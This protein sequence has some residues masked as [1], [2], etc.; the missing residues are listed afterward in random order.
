MRRRFACLA[1]IGWLAVGA[2]AADAATQV[3]ET[4]EP[5]GNCSPRTRIQLSSAGNPYVIPSAGVLTSWS[6]ERASGS[7]IPVR[8]KVA[9]AAGGTSFTIVGE[10]EFENPAVG[11]NT[12]STR[13]AVQAG[14]VLGL[15]AATASVFF[16]T[17]SVLGF[18]VGLGPAFTDE[19]VGMT[20]PY[21][22]V[23]DQQ[24]DVSATLEADCDADGFGDET[25]DGDTNSC[26]PGPQATITK[27][28]RDRVKTRRKRKRATFEFV[29]AEPAT[30]ECALDAAPFT[31]CT[32]PQQVTVKRGTHQFQVRAI[33]AGGNAGVPAIDSWKLKRKRRR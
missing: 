24:L 11:S 8:L 4:F 31:A 25:Q 6:F 27:A 17:R 5:T 9:R 14:D 28:P 19:G 3:G 12:F 30:F 26:P 33:D 18:T 2:S 22:P 1:A 16:C 20:S 15:Y 23:D 29:A 10:S 21:P 32:S 7:A 13:I